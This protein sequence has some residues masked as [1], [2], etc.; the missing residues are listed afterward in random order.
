MT[1]RNVLAA[2]GRILDMARTVVEGEIAI[3][4]MV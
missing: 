3:G 4:A 2:T 1:P